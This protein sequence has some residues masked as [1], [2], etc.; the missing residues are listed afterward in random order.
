MNA[1]LLIILLI[2]GLVSASLAI[3]WLIQ[4]VRNEQSKVSIAWKLLQ[5]HRRYLADN[6]RQYTDL[7]KQ[8]KAQRKAANALLMDICGLENQLTD[9]DAKLCLTQDRL[10]VADQEHTALRQDNAELNDTIDG[11]HVSIGK[12]LETIEEL[13]ARVTALQ[14]EIAGE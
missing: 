3:Y 11:Q 9:K 1:E 4:S 5:D 8:Y 14:T 12:H 6:R 13:R 2:V 7:V 10:K